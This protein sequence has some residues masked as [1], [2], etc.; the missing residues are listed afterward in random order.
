ME[1]V[2]AAMDIAQTTMVRPSM[3]LGDRRESRPSE[4]VGKVLMK[5][6]KPLMLGPLKKYRGIHAGTV[7][8][9]MIIIANS[10]PTARVV[11][12]SDELQEIVDGES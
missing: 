8:Q 3:L 2:I 9:A 1:Q 11:F 5:I 12:E 10:T 6:I 7:A 4:T